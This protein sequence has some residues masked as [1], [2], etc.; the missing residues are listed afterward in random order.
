MIRL[1]QRN[2]SAQAIAQ[3]HIGGLNTKPLVVGI[4]HLRGGVHEDSGLESRKAKHQEIKE[5]EAREDLHRDN[6]RPLILIA[7]SWQEDNIV[8]VLDVL[9][10]IGALDVEVIQVAERRHDHVGVTRSSSARIP[11]TSSAS[12]PGGTRSRAVMPTCPARS[13]SLRATLAATIPFS[14]GRRALHLLDLSHLG[15]LVRARAQQG[16]VVVV[17]PLFRGERLLQVFPRRHPVAPRQFGHTDPLRHE[18]S[19]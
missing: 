9:A 13:L 16:V 17:L 19:E 7:P 2:G 12:A 10:H 4:S 1:I 8:H 18:R 6:E 5:Y 3:A 15:D 14:L 11:S